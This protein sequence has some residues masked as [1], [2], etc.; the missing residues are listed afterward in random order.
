GITCPG[1]ATM[2][3]A[4]HVLEHAGAPAYLARVAVAGYR[5]GCT[6]AAISCRVAGAWPHGTRAGSAGWLVY[7]ACGAR[8]CGCA[9][10]AWVRRNRGVALCALAETTP[11]VVT[12]VFDAY[13]RLGVIAEANR[14]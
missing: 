3:A 4:F 1:I 11:L 10:F 9:T 6:L 8:C 12:A 2:L 5:A 14:G 13:V 7:L